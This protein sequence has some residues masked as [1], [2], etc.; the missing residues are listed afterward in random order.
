[1]VILPF[2]TS[3]QQTVHISYLGYKE[4]RQK[5]L[6][7]YSHVS[8]ISSSVIPLYN[9]FTHYVGTILI[10]YIVRSLIRTFCLSD[11][12]IGNQNVRVK[13]GMIL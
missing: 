10:P 6:M 3:E 2:V 5:Q 1:M 13:Q 12:S 11:Q 8:F 9:F 4:I 7:Y